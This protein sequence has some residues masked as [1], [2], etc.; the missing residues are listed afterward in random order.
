LK[1]TTFAVELLVKCT[2]VAWRA[3]LHDRSIA[4]NYSAF[5][6]DDAL[7]AGK[8]IVPSIERPAAIRPMGVPG[9][10]PVIEAKGWTPS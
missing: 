6:T 4:V 10:V 8:Q 7:R 1:S 3:F 5:A 9:K 2:R